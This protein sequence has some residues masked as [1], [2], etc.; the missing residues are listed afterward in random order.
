MKRL[1][2]LAILAA[3]SISLAVAQDDATPQTSGN[4]AASVQPAPNNPDNV[5]KGSF[6]VQ[7]EKTLN[8]SKLKEGDTVVCK[9][10]TAIRSRSGL[11]IPSGAKVIGH[12]TQAQARSKGDSESTLAIEFDKIEYAKGEE[13]PMKGIFQAVGPSLGERHPD[14]GAGPHELGVAS[15]GGVASGSNL[16]VDAPPPA[17]GVS[18]VPST[19]SMQTSGP[20][21]GTPILRPDSKGVLGVKNL[22]MGSDGALTSA[23]KEVKLDSGLQVLIHAEI[24]LASR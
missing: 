8:S 21:S 11:M 2:V 18:A 16:N 17:N 22:Q 7:L 6:P 23:G 13:I 24:E 20:S 9:T 19:G 12:V 3:L 14:T 5:I 10:A 1:C 4:Q 15:H